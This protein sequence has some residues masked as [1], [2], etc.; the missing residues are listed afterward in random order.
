MSKAISSYPS[1]ERY[2]TIKRRLKEKKGG[3][4]YLSAVDVG[5]REGLKDTEKEKKEEE[6]AVEEVQ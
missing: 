6:P 2:A 1:S 5:K 4:G 3:L